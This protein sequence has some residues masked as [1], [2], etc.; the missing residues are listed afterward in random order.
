LII[1]KKPKNIDLLQPKK[2]QKNKKN[3]Y[4]ISA[5]KKTIRPFINIFLK[6]N[7]YKGKRKNSIT[8]SPSTTI[9]NQK[10]KI[11]HR[12]NRRFI[13]TNVLKKRRNLIQRSYFSRFI[14]RKSQ[15]V[16]FSFVISQDL[17]KET[18]LLVALKDRFKKQEFK[19]K[20]KS[21]NKHKKLLH[22]PLSTRNFLIGTLYLKYLRSNFFANL[23]WQTSSGKASCG[24]FYRGPKKKT[25]HAREQV[26]Q[27]ISNIIGQNKLSTLDIKITPFGKVYKHLFRIFFRSTAIYVRYLLTPR[28]RSHGFTR[29]VKIRRT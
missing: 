15:K 14:L 10:K 24:E 5:K 26:L 20:I 2:N 1:K 9:K 7:I 8:L 21:T 29:S 6:K 4:N 23:I 11:E 16:R 3:I 22:R 27:K 25:M 17:S 12:I 28:K 19:N 13:T 18:V